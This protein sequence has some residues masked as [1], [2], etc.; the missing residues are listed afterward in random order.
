MRR[1]HRRVIAPPAQQ[2]DRQTAPLGGEVSRVM[3][4][5]L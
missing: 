1:R 4:E 3:F 5:I 2:L